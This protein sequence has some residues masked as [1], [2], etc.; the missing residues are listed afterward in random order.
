MTKWTFYK[1]MK[2]R[3]NDLGYQIWTDIVFI[4][5]T[6]PKSITKIILENQESND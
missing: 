5:S 3:E 6:N 1:S 4:L 2:D